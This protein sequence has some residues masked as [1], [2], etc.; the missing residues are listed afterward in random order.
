MKISIIWHDTLIVLRANDEAFVL[1]RAEPAQLVGA[2][3]VDL[4]YDPELRGLAKLRMQIAR[5]REPDNLPQIDYLFKRF[6][7]TRFYGRVTTRRLESPGEWES[8]I[9]YLY[10]Y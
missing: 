9:E 8:D 7:G 1:F 4:V 10:E 5:Q 6:D 3:L 2:N